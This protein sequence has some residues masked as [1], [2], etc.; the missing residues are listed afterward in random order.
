M[1]TV[2]VSGWI[3]ERLE[4]LVRAG[5]Y[6]S[7][8]EAVR[9]AIRRIL[10]SLDMRDVAFKAYMERGVTFQLA[11]EIAGTGYGELL[12]FFLSRGVMPEIGVDD[13]E[14]LTTGADALSGAPAILDAMSLQL[15]LGTGVV[16]F[17]GT[18]FLDSLPMYIPESLKSLAR[19]CVL[20][21]AASRGRRVAPGIFRVVR[22]APN[23][24]GFARRGG[25]TVVEA[26]AILNAAANGYTLV[27][28]DMRTRRLARGMGVRAVPLSSLVYKAYREGRLTREAFLR[29]VERLTSVPV[30]LPREVAEL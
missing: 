15:M 24:H 4:Y 20:K 26:D 7:K 10:E 6:G 17:L 28:E 8:A 19:A 29:V 12:M 27:S 25:M 11:A 21:L 13:V 5:L 23:V 1:T 30:V 14:E 22:S 2:E 18:E 16:E 9:D 3:E